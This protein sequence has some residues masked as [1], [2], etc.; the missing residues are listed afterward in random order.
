M[1]SASHVGIAMVRVMRTLGMLGEV[2]GMAVSLCKK[3]NCMPRD[4]YTNHLSELK[5]MMKKGVKIPDV[6]Q[7][8][9]K[10]DGESYHFK[11][12]GWWYMSSG[13]NTD[14]DYNEAKVTKEQVEKFCYCVEKLG[15]KH[16]YPIPKN[17]T[18]LLS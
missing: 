6:F 11:D 18:D 1:I 12:I 9:G 10:G 13:Y 15:I 14:N 5:E 16:K 2:A 4:V 17:W 7:G 8:N 3:Y